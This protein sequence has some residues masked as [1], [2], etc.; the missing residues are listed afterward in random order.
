MIRL[1]GRGDDE[2]PRFLF[3]PTLADEESSQEL[4]EQELSESEDI[5]SAPSDSARTWRRVADSHG[6]VLSGT[7]SHI[8]S[9]AL[10]SSESD[11]L[12][13]SSSDSIKNG[14]VVDGTVVGALGL[15]CMSVSARNCSRA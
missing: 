12:S 15:S 2:Y 1:L 10:N 3:P 7:V 8:A 14:N 5:T 9:D 4:W 6:Y 13:S 11:N